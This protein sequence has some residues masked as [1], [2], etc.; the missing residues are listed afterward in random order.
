MPCDSHSDLVV[1]VKELRKDVGSV[2][3]DVAYIRGKMDAQQPDVKVWFGPGIQKW[4][5]I[6]AALLSLLGVSLGVSAH[7]DRAPVEIGAPSE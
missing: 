2:K 6:I 7:S 4:G 3:E 1:E 5:T